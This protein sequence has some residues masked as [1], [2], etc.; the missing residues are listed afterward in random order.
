MKPLRGINPLPSGKF[1]LRLQIRGKPLRGFATPE[2]AAIVRDAALREIA[3]QTMVPVA[4]SSMVNLAVS[5]RD[6]LSVPVPDLEIRD[7]ARPARQTRALSVAKFQ[8]RGTR[9][10]R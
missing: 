10:R 7:E 9:T 1:R 3:D 4:G 2:E 5:R 6:I 8:T